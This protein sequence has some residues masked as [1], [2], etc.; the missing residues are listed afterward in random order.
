M[1]AV[2]IA[3]VFRGKALF[4]CENN[5]SMQIWELQKS[6]CDRGMKGQETRE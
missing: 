2:F 5:S 4:F 1:S 6:R 3:S